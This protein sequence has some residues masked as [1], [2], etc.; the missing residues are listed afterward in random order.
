MIKSQQQCDIVTPWY[1]KKHSLFYNLH[2]AN[3]SIQYSFK[4]QQQSASCHFQGR[5]VVYNSVSLTGKITHSLSSSAFVTVA[6]AMLRFLHVPFLPFIS[7][8]FFSQTS[9]SF[10][11]C[12]VVQSSIPFHTTFPYTNDH[13]ETWISKTKASLGLVLDVPIFLPH[14]YQG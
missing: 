11:S 13:Q 9:F 1:Y 7:F 14:V 2:N 4:L 8:L 6:M 12:S 10:P 5:T 3:F